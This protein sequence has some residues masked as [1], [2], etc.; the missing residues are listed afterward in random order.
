MTPL[1]EK[2]ISLIRATGPITVADYMAACLGDPDHGYYVSREPFGRGGDFITAPEVSQMFGELI[3]AWS[4]LTW[5]AMGAPSPFALAELGPGRGTLMADL[6]RATRVRPA[7]GEAARVHLVETSPR[8][9]E[10]QQARLTGSGVKATWHERIDDLPTGPLIVIANEFFDALPIRQFVRTAKGW[11]ERMVGVDDLGRLA[12][13]LRPMAMPVYDDPLGAATLSASSSAKADDRDLWAATS[14]RMSQPIVSGPPVKPEDDNAEAAKVL[15][16]SPAATAIV[17]TLS[18]RLARYGGAALI[19]DY[20]YEGPAVGD[21]LQAVRRH[22]HDDPL[23]AP[24]EADLTAHVDFAA[25]AGAADGAGGVARRLTTQGAFLTR[26]GIVERAARLGEGKDSETKASLQSAVD[27]LCGRQTMGD[28]F[29]VLAV[30]QPGLVLPVFDD[31]V[32]GG[33]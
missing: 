13:G 20:G 11:A 21:T 24:G 30:A 17:G 16:T 2:L 7:F 32:S 23:A 1:A 3:G 8:L 6:L 4:V 10:V 9:R 33:S 27:R 29:K 25:L 19:I 12:F 5:E 28:L 31:D 15:E 26:L 14:S 18:E 22:R